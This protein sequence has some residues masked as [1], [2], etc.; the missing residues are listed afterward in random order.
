M[1]VYIISSKDLENN[2]LNQLGKWLKYHKNLPKNYL[3]NLRKYLYNGIKETIEKETYA[4]TDI[5]ANIDETP[6][7]L[8]RITNV[9]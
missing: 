4:N 9:T 3:E 6:L 8:E 2:I 5:L 1:L 7:V